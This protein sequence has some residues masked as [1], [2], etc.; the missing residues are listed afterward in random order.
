MVTALTLLG[1]SNMND[2]SNATSPRVLDCQHLASSKFAQSLEVKILTSPG[3]YAQSTFTPKA[4]RRE[5]R[6][7]VHVTPYQQVGG[8]AALQILT[9]IIASRTLAPAHSEDTTNIPR[10]DAAS[11]LQCMVCICRLRAFRPDPQPFSTMCSDPPL[12]RR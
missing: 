3:A 1:V 12:G 9:D 10:A 6:T 7:P 11:L 2:S 8:W 5:L 4:T